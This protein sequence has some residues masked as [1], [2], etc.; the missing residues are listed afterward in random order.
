MATLD[1]SRD[2]AAFQAEKARLFRTYGAQ[3][4]V[5]ADAQFQAAFNEFAEAARFALAKF[6]DQPFLIRRADDR[7]A[8]IPMLI[9]E[10]INS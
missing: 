9:V 4:V 2:I 8:A 3:W 7:R 6:H 10:D 5:F 1:L